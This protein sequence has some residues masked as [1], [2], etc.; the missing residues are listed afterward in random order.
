M[1]RSLDYP[2]VPVGALLAGSARRFGDHVAIHYVGR[3]LT[4]EQLYARAC[5]F[6]N[7]LRT[8]MPPDYRGRSACSIRARTTCAFSLAAP[9]RSPFA[10]FDFA[11]VSCMPVSSSAFVST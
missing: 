4:S 10:A 1:T 7:A 6:A 3:D 11:M 9:V 8:E 2:H 5:A